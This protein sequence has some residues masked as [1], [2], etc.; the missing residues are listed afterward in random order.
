MFGFYFVLLNLEHYGHFLRSLQE[1]ENVLVGL[2]D[3]AVQSFN[4]EY[5]PHVVGFRLTLNFRSVF[6]QSQGY[7]K[8]HYSDIGVLVHVFLPEPF[9][10]VH[11]DLR[12]SLFPLY[13]VL[14]IQLNYD[15]LENRWLS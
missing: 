10:G 1:I 13:F 11:I 2:I 6:A 4:L 14:I 9:S 15:W 8:C 12:D 3:Y 5:C 7:A